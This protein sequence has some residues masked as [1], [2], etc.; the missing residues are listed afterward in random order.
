MKKYVVFLLLIMAASLFAAPSISLGADRTDVVLVNS[1][2][3]GLSLSYELSEI[4]AFD[5]NTREGIFTQIGIPGCT[6]STRIGM[7]KL[8]VLRK[9]ITVPLGAEIRLNVSDFNEIEYLLSDFGINNPLMP[10]Q[11]P[12]P[13]SAD[14]ATI[15][16]SFNASSYDQIGYNN[17]ELI[18]VE[19]VGSMRG[20]R[21]VALV[22]EP[23]KYDPIAGKIR[24][25][26]NIS[27]D[28]DFIG[29]NIAATNY[30]R[31]RTYS[32]YFESVFTSS[33]INYNTDLSR[34]QLTRYPVKYVIISDPMFETQLQPF[35]EW[36]I[37]KGFEVIEAYTGD[38][39][40]GTT[41]TS[42][43]AF[44][45]GLY[46][47]GT[48]DDPAPSFV[49][50]VGDV[51]QIPAWNG[52]TGSH[53]TDLNYVK[54]D[55]N[56]IVPDMYYGRFSANNTIELQPQIDKTLMY[57]KYEM[58]DPSYLEEVVMIAGMDT[59]HGSTWGNGQINYGTSNYF[60]LAHG[61]TSHTYL[62]PGSGSSS[63]QIIQNVS[64]GVSYINYTAHGWDQGWADPSFTMANINSLQNS[65]EYCLAVGN[66]CLTNK[67]E[68]QTCFG[69]AW[70]RAE[71]KGA[72]GYIGGTNST[73]WDEDYWWGVGAGAVTA[74][75][76]YAST[77]LGVYDGLFHENGEEFADWTTTTGAMLWRGNMAVTEGGGSINYY[78]EIYSIM[79]DPS[80][81]AYIGLPAVNAANYPSVIFLG[82][83]TIQVS[84]EPYSYVS[85]SKDGEIYG[86]ALIDESGVVELEFDGFTAPGMATLVIT[87]QNNQPILA[88]VEV[89]PAVGPFVIVE[90]FEIFDN[91]NNIPEYDETILLDMSFENVGV[92]DALSV[93]ATI[94]TIDNYVSFISD[95]TTIGD[96][97][98]GTIVSISDAF[99][100][101]IADDIPDQHVITFDIEITTASDSWISNII[102]TFNAPAFEAGMMI[103]D[104][105][106]GNGLLDPGET[107]TIS[108]PVTNIGNALS[109]DIIAELT[110][111]T[112]EYITVINGTFNMNALDVGEEAMAEFEVEVDPGV[113]PGTTAILGFVASGG[114]YNVIS[115]LYPPIGLLFED[116]ETGDFS[117]Y[118]WQL[119]SPGWEIT[120]NDP[121]EGTYCAV[122]AD[123]GDNQLANI[124]VTMDVPVDGEIRFYRKVSS[125]ASYDYLKF[126]TNGTMREEWSGDISWSE[127]VFDVSAGA[128]V[129]FKWVY[130]KDYSVSSG[131]DCAWIDYIVFPG[132]GG[133]A[134]APIININV[135]EINFGEVNV[136][137]TAVEEFT[138]FNL[139]TENLT[140]SIAATEDFTLSIEDYD[141]PA[142]SSVVVEVEFSPIQ[143]MNYFGDIVV[144]SND[145][146]Q[147]L[148]E[149]PV[150]GTGVATNSDPNLI[151]VV[152]KLYGNYPN[153]FNPITN[154]SYGLSEDSKVSIIIYNI[155]GQ[156][157]KTL[158]N[159]KQEAGYHKTMWNGRDDTN[160]TATSGVYFYEIFVEETDYTSIKKMILLK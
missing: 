119:G 112:P 67:F 5:V 61:I 78:W 120:S 16:F 152:T 41:T 56:N 35:I 85:L 94:S 65:G 96:I 29:G 7:A 49:L 127:V 44:L 13:K 70:L 110:S 140:G 111:A 100:I 86:T 154:I 158:I 54:L 144:T 74:N 130:D 26:N 155:K 17:A 92:E 76:T 149:I 128:N 8:P 10:A 51:A 133:G 39:N 122:S 135:T 50:F 73:Y 64:D 118:N 19:E 89:V 105:S 88:E 58:P 40:V 43:K 138:I 6:Y 11:L 160:K 103:I 151:P 150:E 95:T 45:Q 32:H 33:I 125:E 113:D 153:P 148:I 102:I 71:D 63:A 156:K 117:Q 62:Y 14:P 123:I 84:A 147:P 12:A 37:E 159:K 77:G 108:I 2:D 81:E 114:Q 126:Y 66:C 80:L 157:V 1:S 99:E 57:E 146:N 82:I 116:F 91:N 136:G 21:I 3:Y 42:I 53:I 107:A 24:I 143:A 25:Y 20:M 68:V 90:S 97:V 4:N 104:D 34:D 60:N 131:S 93:S 38:P 48:P 47:A 23:V 52:S 115:T 46:D 129:E 15:S 87:K 75:P 72:I 27:V 79:G 145:A 101:E 18:S 69:E 121:Y 30:E 31:Q 109:P 36:K 28:V 106:G 142:G 55:G 132:I 134:G 141:L 98:A 59:S 22:L 9:L 139:G 83:T 137:E 124:T